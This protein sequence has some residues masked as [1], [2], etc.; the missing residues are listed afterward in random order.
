MRMVLGHCSNCDSMHRSN[1]L[2]KQ[3]RYHFFSLKWSIV[4][5][6]YKFSKFCSI[7]NP[8]TTKSFF[9]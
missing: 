3:F 8:N 2:Y 7:I 1:Y 4:D 9:D 6:R 5:S